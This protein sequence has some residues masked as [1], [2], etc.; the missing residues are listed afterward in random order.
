MALNS[1]SA[2][3]CCAV[4]RAARPTISRVMARTWSGVFLIWYFMWIGLVEMNVWMPGDL[5]LLHRVP[6]DAHVLLDGAGQSGDTRAPDL[7]GDQ[8]HRLE[9]A[10]RGDRKAGLDDVDAHALEL[11]GDLELLGLVHRRAGRLLAVAQRGVEDLDVAHAGVAGGDPVGART[12]GVVWSV[13]SLTPPRISGY[14]SAP[15][16]PASQ[17]DRRKGWPNGRRCYASPRGGGGA[18][19]GRGNGAGHGWGPPWDTRLS[20][21]T[22]D[23]RDSTRTDAAH[24]SDGERDGRRGGGRGGCAAPARRHPAQATG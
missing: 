6:A 17:K 7:A 18:G 22:H 21:A 10:L 4:R 3:A 14:A 20:L 12:P 8:G 1:T 11:A 13:T 24:A 15:L 19:R 16:N 23:L 9:V 2:A 5:G